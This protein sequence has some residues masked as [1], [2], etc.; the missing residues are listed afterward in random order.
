MPPELV[1]PARERVAVVVLL[2]VVFLFKKI[3]QK[4]K[5][6]QFTQYEK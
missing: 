6:A 1:P 2:L 4:Y 3:I 5:I